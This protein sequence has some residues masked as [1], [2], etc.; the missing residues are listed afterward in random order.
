MLFTLQNQVVRSGT[1]VVCL[2]AG[3]PTL[4]ATTADDSDAAVV[5]VRMSAVAGRS[6]LKTGCGVI[7]SGCGDECG[8]SA[9]SGGL[10]SRLLNN[11]FRGS[12]EGDSAGRGSASQS[13]PL[14][15]GHATRQILSRQVAAA[16]R[17]RWI[18]RSYDFDLS[19]R[20]LNRR[21][22]EL[23]Q[24][25]LQQAG[26]APLLIEKSAV[27]ESADARRREAVRRELSGSSRSIP[28]E[29][30]KMVNAGYPG[31]SADDA[32][33]IHENRSEQ[34]QTQGVSPAFGGGV[35]SGGGLPE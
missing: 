13:V 28:V 3:L 12:C 10:L 8:D 32:A 14:P 16:K 29:S 30:L 19:N 5:P 15:H 18:V 22:R 27:G 20:I 21:G 33:L 17:Y 7:R 2:L 9:A 1:A 24:R 26:D 31:I 11:V 23:V 25:Y 34:T 4:S 35:P 6:T